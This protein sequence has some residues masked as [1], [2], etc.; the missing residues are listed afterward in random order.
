VVHSGINPPVPD[1]LG[2]DRLDILNGPLE[3]QLQAHV[4]ETDPGVG[5]VDP[6]QPRPDDVVP[7]A[8]NEVPGLVLLEDARVL[9][10]GVVEQLQVPDA[11]R[12]GGKDTWVDFQGYLKDL[13]V[14]QKARA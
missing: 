1:R 14:T 2:D 9:L 4:L 8:H 10:G 5:Q 12:L 3:A 13:V 6:P 11:H 7:Q